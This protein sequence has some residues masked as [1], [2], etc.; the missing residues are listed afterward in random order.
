M[1]Y[2][3]DY[4]YGSGSGCEEIFDTYEDALFYYQMHYTTEK[5]RRGIVIV[6]FEEE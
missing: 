4:E 5:E 2:I 6:E 1:K 3:I